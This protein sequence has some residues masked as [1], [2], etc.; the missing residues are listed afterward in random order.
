[1]A[2]K[3]KKK[4]LGKGIH[5]LLSNIDQTIESTPEVVV[6]QLSNT[7]A[8]IPV[9]TI[10]LN[11]YQPRK[12]FDKQALADLSQS[13][14]I[15]GLI[16]PIT[17]RR[18]NEKTYQLIS[19]ERRWRASQMA[20]LTKIPAYIR[21]ANDQEM[22]EMALIENIQREDLNAIEISITYQR[23]IDECDLTHES[24]SD[25]VGKNRS[26]I[27]NY[28]RLLKLP[29]QIQQAIKEKNI[30]M[31]HARALVG[32]QDLATQLSV[33]NQIVDKK[34]SVRDTESLIRSYH[35][36]SEGGQSKKV[37]TLPIEYQNIQD[38][39]RD[40]FGAKVLLKRKGKGKGQIIINYNSD[41]DL[42]RLIDLIDG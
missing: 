10:E 33:Y 3:I 21:I 5:A 35:S 16:Q 40:H 17:V 29:P 42:N 20:G 11:P 38:T 8:E 13:I 14:S 2:K 34:L 1:M 37:K 30:S 28:L 36:A 9:E 4:E 27:T 26:T 22:L 18:L 23:L 25:R 19:G 41:D 12:E 32:I 6:Q 24:M 31:G 15:H 39:L 7:V